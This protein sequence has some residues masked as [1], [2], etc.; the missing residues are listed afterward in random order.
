M[1]TLSCRVRGGGVEGGRRKTKNDYK[2]NLEPIED[3][4]DGR[5]YIVTIKRNRKSVTITFKTLLVSEIRK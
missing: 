3:V 5:Q 2:Y 1:I 4:G